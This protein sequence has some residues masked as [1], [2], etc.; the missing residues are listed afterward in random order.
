MQIDVPPATSVRAVLLRLD[1][2]QLRELATLSKVNVGTLNNIRV[3]AT[4][5]FTPDIWASSRNWARLR[6]F[7]RALTAEAGGMSMF[8]R[9]L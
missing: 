5:T 1:S 3:G 4:P 6:R 2:I 9:R 7:R 8:M